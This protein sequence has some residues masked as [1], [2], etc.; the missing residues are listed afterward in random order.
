MK[1]LTI[2]FDAEYENLAFIYIQTISNRSNHVVIKFGMSLECISI[3]EDAY[4]EC[5]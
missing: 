2:L 5:L 1:E 3:Q 4:M